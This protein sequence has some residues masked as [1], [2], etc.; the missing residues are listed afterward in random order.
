MDMKPVDSASISAIGY[1]AD[2]KELHVHFVNGGEY[3]YFDVSPEKH[4][5]LMSTKSHG[6][7][8]M[9]TIRRSHKCERLD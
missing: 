1:D 4:A 3:K 5:A 7:H 6:K 8:F 9:S 2:S